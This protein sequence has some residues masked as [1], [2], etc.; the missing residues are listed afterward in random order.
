MT[1]QKPD[2][3]RCS[4]CGKHKPIQPL[5][6]ECEERHRQAAEQEGTENTR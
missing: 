3:W 5:A 6:R 4:I 1:D 2:P